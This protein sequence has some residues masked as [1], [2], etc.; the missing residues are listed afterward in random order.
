VP[1]TSRS[2]IS[3]EEALAQLVH[4]A[5]HRHWAPEPLRQFDHGTHLS[6]RR[7]LERLRR[8]LGR[9][10]IR[11]LLKHLLKYVTRLRLEGLQELPMFVEEPM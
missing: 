11:E 5:V 4:C 6:E 7:N 8:E 9:A 1:A 2:P 10:V 3:L